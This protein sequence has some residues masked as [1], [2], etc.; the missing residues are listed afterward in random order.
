MTI[1]QKTVC[2]VSRQV[3]NIYSGP[4]LYTNLLIDSLVRKNYKVIV[5]SDINERVDQGPII[6]IGKPFSTKFRNHAH[7][8]PFSIGIRPL[9]KEIEKKYQPKIIH[10][11]EFRDG[12]FCDCSTPN[13]SNLN[14][15]YTVNPNSLS[16]YKKYYKDWI[17]RWLYYR[18]SNSLEKNL[19]FKMDLPIANSQYTK[20]IFEDNYP[21]IRKI[22]VIHKGVDINKYQQLI[23]ERQ[24]WSKHPPRIL[25]V[26]GNMQRKGLPVLLHSMPLILEQ[27]K[28][29]MLWVVGSDPMIP[30]FEQTAKKMGIHKQIAFLGH[31]N[32]N[33]LMK[34]YR[35]SDIL[36]LPALIEAF[37]VVILEAM[38]AGLPV[39]ASQCGGIPEIITNGENGYLVPPFDYEKL[40][41]SIVK[42]LTDDDLR[43]LFI[44]NGYETS[45]RF[46]A[47]N[48]INA[49]FKLYD[50]FF[51]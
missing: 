15:T 24:D 47:E 36:A 32:Q 31:K 9:V 8:I 51:E 18:L 50:D 43:N 30:L 42:L 1:S 40:G 41:V 14:D 21:K 49:T 17:S 38:A 11:T 7:W 33:D 16:F 29:C 35:D 23:V 45:K 6:F 13:I 25:F 44:K 20:K 28:D 39:V 34:C 37:G 5:L 4:G 26:G 19:V 12:L 22:S 27:V 3:K 2:V 46:S 48:M 10:F